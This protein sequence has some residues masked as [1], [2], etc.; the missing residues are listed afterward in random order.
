M[1]TPVHTA[2]A[3]SSYYKRPSTQ[4]DRTFRFLGRH[5]R[6]I[7]KLFKSQT[8]YVYFIDVVGFLELVAF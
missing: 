4:T 1:M 6:T 8:G 2:I 5:T 3:H 7:I